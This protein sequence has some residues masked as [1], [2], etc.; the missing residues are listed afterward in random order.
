MRSSPRHTRVQKW[1]QTGASNAVD[2]DGLVLTGTGPIPV[3]DGI[4]IKFSTD[5]V[6]GSFRA[7]DYWVI[8]ARTATARIDELTNA[9]PRGIIHHYV[10]LAAISG[11]GTSQPTIT[12]C[13]PSQQKADCCCTVIIRPGENIQAGIDALP[14]QGGCVCLKTGLH[15]IRKPLRIARG[16]IAL[17]GESPGAIVKSAGTGPVLIIGNAAGFPIDGIEIDGIGFVA[18]I[19]GSVRGWSDLYRLRSACPHCS[20]RYQRGP[21]SRFYWRPCRHNRRA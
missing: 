21:A 2:G 16:N 17:K 1:N 8:W 4:E 11:L 10:Q 12:D 19:R 13:R 7:G 9:P 6:G 20:V 15:V 18:N 5:P 14:K 3:E